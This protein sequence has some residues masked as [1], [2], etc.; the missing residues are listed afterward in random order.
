[1]SMVDRLARAAA[2][3]A[4]G[5]RVVAVEDARALRWVPV[6]GPL[7]LSTEVG[8]A[9][10][11]VFDVTLLAWREAASASPLALRARGHGPGAARPGL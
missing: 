2:R 1:M 4:P 9:G 7:R 8:P 5:R 11:G 6:T 10:D 3:L